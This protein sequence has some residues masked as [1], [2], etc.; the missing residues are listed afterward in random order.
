M[1]TLCIQNFIARDPQTFCQ[2]YANITITFLNRVIAESKL[3][4]VTA[5][6]I[7]VTMFEHVPPQMTAQ[8]ILP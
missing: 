3:D 2:Q 5:M 8:A 1:V 4:A 7:F 6:K